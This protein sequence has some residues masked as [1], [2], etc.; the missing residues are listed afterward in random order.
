[1]T[2]TSKN[3]DQNDVFFERAV[4]DVFGKNIYLYYHLLF[5]IVCRRIDY[6]LSNVLPDSF[7][8]FKLF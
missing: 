7:T 2:A 1:M 8:V 5:S 3:V 4:G 6:L